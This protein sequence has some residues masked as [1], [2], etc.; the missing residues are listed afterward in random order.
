[1]IQDAIDIAEAR[2]DGMTTLILAGTQAWSFIVD[3]LSRDRR[4]GGDQMTLKGW[5][6]AV[7]FN[8]IPIVKD[9][10]CPE[11]KMFGLDMN[12]WEFR[13]NDKGHFSGSDLQLPMLSQVPG[14]HAYRAD[15]S[16]RFQPICYV[17]AANWIIEDVAYVGL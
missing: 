8:D 11:D 7:K 1:L 3:R 6:Q 14:K 17:P 12:T 10:L 4:Y 15:W 16:W 5:A 2:S 9:H 13:Q